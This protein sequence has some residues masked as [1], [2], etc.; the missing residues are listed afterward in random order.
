MPNNRFVLGLLAFLFAF[1]T[2]GL[3]QD[4]L[5]TLIASPLTPRTI[6]F[7]GTDGKQH[8]VYELLLTN[9]R[10]TPA[11]VTRIEFLSPAPASKILAS[12]DGAELLSHLRNLGNAPVTSPEIE[13]NSG[14]LLLVDLTFNSRAD[15]PSQLQHRLHLL[16][17]SQPGPVKEPPV[18]ITYT[19]SP[20]SVSTDSLELGPPVAGKGWVAMN[21]CCGPIG[22]H[23]GTGIPV[24]G[25][26]YFAQ[27][28][29]IDWMLLDSQGRLMHGDVAD[30]HSYP[31]YGRD[32]LAVADG[33]VV[34]TFN[35]LKDQVPGELPDPKTITMDNVDG[36][37]I[38]LDLGHNRYAFYAHLQ[39]DSLR[40]AL[41]DHV[42]RGQVL[43]K[44]GN[45]GNT[46]SPHLHFHLMEGASVLG[47]HGIPYTIDRL[48]VAGELSKKQFDE[49]KGVEGDW[50]K[51]LYPQ[52]IPRTDEFP[53]D[54]MIIDF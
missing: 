9:T 23:R 29:A 32:V 42:K 17:A 28:F 44:V 12:Y 37:H 54:R 22:A 51:G 35:D 14:R 11:T 10:P 39:K 45:T 19:I 24:N 8:V 3:S 5:T 46:S 26:I 31:C 7:A 6:A 41:G 18:P 36:N 34:A 40:V 13:F 16:A 27:R 25:Q 30:V 38:V 47:S 43:A 1:T 49:A 2:F 50:S 33:T 15:V 4:A 20:V 48:S 52:P 21:G 53:L